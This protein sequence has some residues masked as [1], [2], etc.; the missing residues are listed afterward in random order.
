[1]RISILFTPALE[2][3]LVHVTPMGQTG[4]D[5]ESQ[6]CRKSQRN[7]MRGKILGLVNQTNLVWILN[8]PCLTGYVALG[9]VLPSLRFAFLVSTWDHTSK[10]CSEITQGNHSAW[11]Q[12]N[13]RAI[14]LFSFWQVS[15][16][17]QPL[18]CPIYI[19]LHRPP[20]TKEC[21][22]QT[23]AVLHLKLF[24]CFQAHA[25]WPVFRA[26]QS[27]DELMPAEAALAQWQMGIAG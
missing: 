4:E 5:H 2:M 26:S 10:F 22:L 24:F 25:F 21:L 12:A 14:A 1:M 16:L 3:A 6:R 27:A 11:C 8:P 15:N 23:P 17:E 20:L 13:S 18:W 7:G 9:K 19:L